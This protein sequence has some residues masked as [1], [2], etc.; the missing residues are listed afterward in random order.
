MVTPFV[1]YGVAHGRR[2]VQLFFPE[3]GLNMSFYF[4]W[5]KADEPFDATHHARQDESLLHFHVDHQQGAVPL[6]FLT[7]PST[8]PRPRLT[9][10]R[11]VLWQKKGI[12]P[13]FYLTVF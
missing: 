11:G 5:L 12:Y 1:S 10:Q 7:V 2:K 3:R 13:T 8:S 9:G 4:V 6:L